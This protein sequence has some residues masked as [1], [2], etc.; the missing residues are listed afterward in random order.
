MRKA[1][2]EKN[3]ISLSPF[4]FAVG[5]TPICIDTYFIII[6]KNIKCWCESSFRC[7][8]LLFNLYRSLNSDYFSE[9]KHSWHFIPELLFKIP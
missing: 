1:K 7:F 2:C 8:E 6:N 5:L 9:S 4:G 3:N